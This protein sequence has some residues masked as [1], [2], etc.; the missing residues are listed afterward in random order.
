MKRQREERRGKEREDEL[1]RPSDR[2]RRGEKFGSLGKLCFNK[3]NFLEPSSLEE[4]NSLGSQW[5]ALLGC[6]R[7]VEM[8]MLLLAALVG[9]LLAAGHAQSVVS[10]MDL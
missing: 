1:A 3:A 7:Q 10:L 5:G 6:G 9:T 8:K 4:S 2:F